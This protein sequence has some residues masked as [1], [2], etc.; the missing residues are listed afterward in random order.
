MLNNLDSAIAVGGAI[1][2]SSLLLIAGTAD[3]SKMKPVYFAG[4][5]IVASAGKRSRAIFTRT[6]PVMNIIHQE[7]VSSNQEWFKQQFGTSNDQPMEATLINDEVPVQI[8]TAELDA[9]GN[10][11]HLLITG[12]TGEGKSTIAQHLATRLGGS[13]V[14]IDPH[15]T[16]SDWNG[17]PV[18]GKGRDYEAIT[19][20]M[21]SQI[22]EMNRRYSRRAAGQPYGE[23]ISIICDEYAAICLEEVTKKIAPNWF[24]TLAT[25][26]RKVEMQLILLT[27]SDSVKTLQ[28]EGKGNLRENFTHLRLGKFALKH[29]KSLKDEAIT[30]WLSSQLRPAMLDDLPLAI[31]Q[32]QLTAGASHSLPATNQG[33]QLSS[34]EVDQEVEVEAIEDKVLEPSVT[35]QA[36]TNDDADY[37][38]F[39]ACEELLKVGKSKSFVVESVLGCKGRKFKSGMERLNALIERFGEG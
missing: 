32:L 8:Q 26:A 1:A 34:M 31:P 19:S 23:K 2:G 5:A 37:A 35:S 25:E 16:P 13:V 10:S 27:Q 12:S 18:V 36:T 29:G 39:L 17:L 20:L 22:D 9:A 33:K 4:S 14:V 15:A 21:E 6:K 7:S 38:L 11:T 28:L 3:K 30:Q 24:Q